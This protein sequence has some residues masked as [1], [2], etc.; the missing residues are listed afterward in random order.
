[1]VHIRLCSDVDYA[2]REAFDFTYKHI[3]SLELGVSCILLKE[4]LDFREL[5]IMVL[6]GM[7][8]RYP[9]LLAIFQSKGMQYKQTFNKIIFYCPHGVISTCT[10]TVLCAD[11]QGIS[12]SQCHDNIVQVRFI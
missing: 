4:F 6:Q 8:C 3:A 12:L 10:V 1:M 5:P 2:R 11:E 7:A 9:A